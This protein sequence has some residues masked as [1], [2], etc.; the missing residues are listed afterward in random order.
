MKK[1]DSVIFD[2]IQHKMLK[3]NERII[4]ANKLVYPA[5]YD[6][7]DDEAYYK[8]IT[9][10]ESGTIRKYIKFLNRASAPDKWQ[11]INTM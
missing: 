10:D 1:D 3:L 7:Q 6:D 2:F 5:V 11:V 4:Y 8:L 9:C